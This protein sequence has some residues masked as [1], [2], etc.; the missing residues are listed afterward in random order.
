MVHVLARVRPSDREKKFRMI[1]SAA[2][3]FGCE[4]MSEEECDD[5]LAECGRCRL[6][7]AAAGTSGVPLRRWRGTRATRYKV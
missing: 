3:H 6:P 4:V 1:R 2:R 7:H 5:W